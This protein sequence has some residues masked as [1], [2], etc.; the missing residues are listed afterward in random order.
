MSDL[1][2]TH[3]AA[4]GTLL[5]G[6]SKGD[7]AG[8][9]LKAH[10]WRW[11]RTVGQWGILRSRDSR[12]DRPKIDRTAAALREQ[13]WTVTV[14]IDDAARPFAEAEAERRQH[15]A[16]RIDRLAD[17]NDRKTSAAEASWQQ[18][19]ELAD[20]MPLGQ[21]IVNDKTRRAYDK[22]HRAQDRAM[23]DHQAQR[24]SGNKLAAAQV[25]ASHRDNP[26]TVANRIDRIQA[27]IRDRERKLAGYSN[28]PVRRRL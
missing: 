3:T 4:E 11:F 17:R 5:D 10:G 6:T 23:T 28:H 20:R 18:A 24:H 2:V 7:G 16:D 13:G 22:I 25:N 14:E 15:Q 8:P 21:P 12:A 27:E 26:Q 1:S 9:I 19:H